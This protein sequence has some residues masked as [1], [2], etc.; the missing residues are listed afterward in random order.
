MATGNYLALKF[1]AAEGVTQVTVQMIPGNK[2]AQALDE[3]MNA[4][5]RVA[6][7]DQ[8]IEVKAYTA[9]G[10]VQTTTLSLT[11]LTLETAEDNE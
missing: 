7:L 5:F 3:D 11:G 9:Q 8:V 4:V 2:P 10:L 6:S 1:T